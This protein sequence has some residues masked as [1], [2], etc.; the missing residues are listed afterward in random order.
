M[1]FWSFLEVDLN[2]FD[3]F[4]SFSDVCKNF[5]PLLQKFWGFLVTRRLAKSA[6]VTEEELLLGCYS[7]TKC[8]KTK[9][10]RIEIWFF[11]FFSS[12]GENF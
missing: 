6:I 9:Q 5:E 1:F 7:N 12:F 11:L 2:L 3:V 4:L 8:L 10:P